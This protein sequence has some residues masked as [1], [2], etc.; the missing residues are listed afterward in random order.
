MPLQI[1]NVVDSF[2]QA[3]GEAMACVDPM[4]SYFV[5][6]GLDLSRIAGEGDFKL[7]FDRDDLFDVLSDFC[8]NRK[9]LGKF[10]RC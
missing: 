1:P 3:L 9:L 5:A 7:L 6:R 8:S 2:L 4:K 10:C